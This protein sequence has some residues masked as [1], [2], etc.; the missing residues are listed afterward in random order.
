M[1]FEFTPNEW[2]IV[3]LAV[4]FGLLVGAAMA[5]G[6]GRKHKARYKAEAARVQ[7]LTR[8]NELLRKEV[9]N[10]EALRGAPTMRESERRGIV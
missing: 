4:L 5:S 9:K 10:Q 8:E 6:G 7:E 3:L 1:G 2:L